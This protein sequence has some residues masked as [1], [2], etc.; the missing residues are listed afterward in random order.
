MSNKNRCIT[1]Y[2]YS[3]DSTA[4]KYKIYYYYSS[5]PTTLR[6]SASIKYQQYIYP[7]YDYNKTSKTCT[8]PAIPLKLGI[9]YHQYK[10]L[11]ALL[12]LLLGSSFLFA[13]LRI[14]SRK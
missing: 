5:S 1:D 7:G 12:G 6:S 9:Q 10:M 4:S 2:Y 11:M 14:F 8:P 3:W 13:L